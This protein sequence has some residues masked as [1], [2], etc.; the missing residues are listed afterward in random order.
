MGFTASISGQTD[1]K[2][3]CDKIIDF[4]INCSCKETWG[5]S[6]KTENAYN[7][8]HWIMINHIMEALR[9]H[10]DTIFG[11]KRYSEYVE[12]RIKTMIY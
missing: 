10:L 11:R 3:P 7:S 1:S 2:P 4:M 9:E 6:C 8:H 5:L 12:F